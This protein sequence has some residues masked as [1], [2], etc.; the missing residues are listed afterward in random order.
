MVP[1]SILLM[2]RLAG[3]PALK[4]T[5]KSLRSAVEQDRTSDLQKDRSLSCRVM[6][7]LSRCTKWVYLRIVYTYIC[8]YIHVICT[9]MYMYMYNI[10]THTPKS[11]FSSSYFQLFHIYMTFW[12]STLHYMANPRGV[13]QGNLLTLS[14]IYGSKTTYSIGVAIAR[15]S[16]ALL[17]TPMAIQAQQGSLCL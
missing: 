3:T 7:G 6:W 8:I 17:V 1:P 2:G 13:Q 10:H 5:N 4:R 9:H 11:H 16:W 12:M 15:P 14:C